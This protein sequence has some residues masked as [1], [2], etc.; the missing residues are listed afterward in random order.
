MACSVP[1]RHSLSIWACWVSQT[2][3]LISHL[4]GRL[5]G[6]SG[7]SVRGLKNL[8]LCSLKAREGVISRVEGSR[9]DLGGVQVSG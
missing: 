1:C 5:S 4:I 9:G 6:S 3:G 7:Y 8:T 2:L